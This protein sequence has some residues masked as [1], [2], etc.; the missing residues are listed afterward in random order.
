MLA[1][2]G[3]SLHALIA[4]LAYIIDTAPLA[5]V[6][7]PHLK[8]THTS[9]CGCTTDS[10]LLSLHPQSYPPIFSPPPPPPLLHFQPQTALAAA[11]VYMRLLALPGASAHQVFAGMLLRT[12]LKTWLRAAQAMT[13]R[14]EKRGSRK[15]AAKS[16]KGKTAS[17]GADTAEADDEDNDEAME[18]A[19]GARRMM[20]AMNQDSDAEEE[21]QEDDDGEQPLMLS[22]KATEL[23]QQGLHDLVHFLRSYNLRENAE[24][25]DLAAQVSNIHMFRC[26]KEEKRGNKAQ[27]RATGLKKLVRHIPSRHGRSW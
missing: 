7:S 13:P 4:V 21:E 9:L 27:V 5:K 6:G 26:S 12:A 15:G 20:A 23:V 19:A 2:H 24:L 17:A 8:D 14:P 1:Q 11:T 16:R 18:D 22:A 3:V 10:F 25:L